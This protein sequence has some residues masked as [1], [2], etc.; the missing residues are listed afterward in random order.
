MTPAGTYYDPDIKPSV[1]TLRQL[2]NWN[3]PAFFE[4]LAAW[5]AL[6]HQQQHPEQWPELP[7][8]YNG[9]I[10]WNTQVQAVMDGLIAYRGW[11]A[12]K[13]VYYGIDDHLP[14]TAADTWRDDLAYENRLD[15]RISRRES[16]NW[17]HYQ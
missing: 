14:Q 8:Y 12:V 3:L 17:R 10:K 15:S 2:V 1:V 16:T 9:N 4:A 13:A 11:E 6:Q 7:R 5:A